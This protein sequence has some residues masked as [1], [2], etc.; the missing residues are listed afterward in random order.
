MRAND[1]EFFEGL[2]ARF[3]RAM[4]S[5]DVDQIAQCIAE[6]WVLVTPE[7]GPVSREAILGAIATG[8]LSHDTM[9]KS[10]ARVA[11]YGDVAIVTG[12]GRNT[13]RFQGQAISA[14]EWITDVYRQTESGWKCVLTHLTPAAA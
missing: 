9:S 14:D 1:T 11:V 5:N 3:N 7:I 6:D 2:E 12:R 4:V 13:G 10:L 8:R